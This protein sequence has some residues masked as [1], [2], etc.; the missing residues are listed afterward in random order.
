MLLVEPSS[1][2]HLQTL[3]V[4][5]EK[6]FDRFGITVAEDYEIVS[7][8]LKFSIEHLQQEKVLPRWGTHLFVLNEQRILIGI[9]GY[10]GNR[11]RDGMV[12]IGY[13]IA[14]SY[15]NKG[16]ATQ[17]ASILINRAFASQEVK[18]V[19]AHTLPFENP[20]T[21]VLKKVGMVLIGEHED[22]EDGKV[23]RWEVSPLSEK[24]NKAV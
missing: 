22:K 3:L 9:G 15:Q 23:W 6:F 2:H 8:W 19:R 7:E 11:D 5:K 4:G 24:H 18:L 14:P 1:I 12:E 20:S 21:S 10:K 13:S 16:L 17:A